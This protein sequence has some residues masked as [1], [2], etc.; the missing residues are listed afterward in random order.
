MTGTGKLSL[1]FARFR[2]SASSQPFMHYFDQA[3]KTTLWETIADIE[4]HSLV[5]LVV[6]VKSRSERYADIPFLWGSALAFITFTFMMFA[7]IVFGDYALYIAPI[8]AFFIGLLSARLFPP[9]QWLLISKKRRR[10]SVE[11]MAR[12]FFQKGG[13]RHTQEK[14][15]ILI[16]CSLFEQMVYL[17]PDRGA[18]MAI[19]AEEWEQITQGFQQIFQER[20]PAQALL[21]HLTTCQP[22]FSRYIPPVDHD[23]NELPDDVEIDL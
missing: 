6:V 9:A 10:R 7:P 14:I 4:N 21:T 3:F 15:G 5:E 23:I 12:A 18:E 19:P 11:I 8:I 22:V 16:Y 20:N 2:N 13:L 17:L 1:M